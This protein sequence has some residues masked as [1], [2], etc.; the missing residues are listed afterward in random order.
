MITRSGESELFRR[1]HLVFV[2][3]LPAAA[4]RTVAGEEMDSPDGASMA[5]R[6][7]REPVFTF[8][9]PSASPSAH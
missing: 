5:W 8:D 3:H 9:Q 7:L 1:R 2:L 6:D 4:A